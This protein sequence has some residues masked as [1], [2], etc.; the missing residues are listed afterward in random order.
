[1]NCQTDDQR[2]MDARLPDHVFTRARARFISE[3]R[4][5]GKRVAVDATLPAAGSPPTF[6]RVCPGSISFRTPSGV[7]IVTLLVLSWNGSVD[8]LIRA[9]RG[10]DLVAKR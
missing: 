5:A 6:G 9:V 3:L 4:Y 10:A 2:H 1:R 7:G 8:W